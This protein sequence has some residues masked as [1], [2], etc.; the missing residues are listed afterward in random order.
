MQHRNPPEIGY[1]DHAG[2]RGLPDPVIA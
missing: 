1:L 2:Q